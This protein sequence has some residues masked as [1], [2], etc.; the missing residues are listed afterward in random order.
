MGQEITG[1]ACRIWGA[2]G[3]GKC[4]KKRELQGSGDTRKYAWHVAI[5]GIS[6]KRVYRG[7]N[8]MGRKGNEA[9]TQGNQRKRV[10]RGRDEMGR[11]GNGT[12]KEKF[13]Q[14]LEEPRKRKNTRQYRGKDDTG[15]WKDSSL[16]LR[17]TV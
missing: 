6:G 14:N 8:S 17:M 10:C 9:T 1:S 7:R 13:L 3:F 12:K 2:S 4:L 5:Q 16:T 15:G 11:R